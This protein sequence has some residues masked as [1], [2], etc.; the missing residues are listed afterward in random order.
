MRLKVYK[1]VTI[2]VLLMS[3]MAA[4]AQWVNSETED[5]MTGRK[6]SFA[7]SPPTK[8]LTRIDFPYEGVISKISVGCSKY[9]YWWVILKLSS[10][11]PLT[12]DYMSGVYGVVKTKV[13][14]NDDLE[15][16]TVQQR[17]NSDII[18]FRKPAYVIDKI[19]TNSTLLL[20]LILYNGEKVHFR[21]D[22]KGSSISIDS[23]R[24]T[25]SKY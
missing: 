21:Y 17:I 2:T 3:S 4:S 8:P 24:K 23:A 15:D 10:S 5:V 16:V 22:L 20:E 14:Y 25:C 1:L 6:S 7:T 12:P 11:L 19:K 13:K 9:G 18:A